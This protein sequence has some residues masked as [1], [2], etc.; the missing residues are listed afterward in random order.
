MCLVTS[1][2]EP[3]I[4]PID[5]PVVK[6]LLREGCYLTYFRRTV[7]KLNRILQPYED[8]KRFVDR[9][10]L[11]QRLGRGLIH[12]YLSA[13]YTIYGEDI[14]AAEWSG[15]CLFKAYIPKG[16]EF[17][18]SDDYKTIAATKLYITSQWATKDFGLKYRE[19]YKII[20]DG[21]KTEKR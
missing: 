8:Y 5:I 10:Q 17:F 13:K 12:A 3:Y 6:V 21:A 15:V 16:T 18:V 1:Q 19:L 4:A 14:R 20:V 11:K 7:V 2:L 9:D